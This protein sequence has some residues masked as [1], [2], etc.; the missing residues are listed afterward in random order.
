[1]REIEIETLR[2]RPTAARARAEAERREKHLMHVRG[3]RGE[4]LASDSR[5]CRLVG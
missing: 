5:G 3:A 1:M 4:V 2:A